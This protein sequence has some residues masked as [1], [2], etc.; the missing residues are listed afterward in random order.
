M[1]LPE[2]MPDLAAIISHKVTGEH[3]RSAFPVAKCKPPPSGA[4]GLTI[5]PGHTELPGGLGS[6]FRGR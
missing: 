2:R 3:R 4:D 6:S 1:N 5:S